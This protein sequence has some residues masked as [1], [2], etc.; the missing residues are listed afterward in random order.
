M[1]T[2][3]KSPPRIIVVLKLPEY[4]VPLLV[5]RARSI[6]ERMTGNQWFPSPM[7]SLAAVQAALED[8]FEAQA[9]TLSGNK[10]SVP[11]RDGKRTV[12]VLRL[13]QLRSYVEAIATA[14][15]EN[16][17]SIIESAGMYL[18]TG[19]G[20]AGRVFTAKPG[21]VSGE[22]DLVAPKA[23]NRAGYEFQH[24]LDGGMTWL[25]LPEPFTTKASVTFRRLK[26]GSTV[27]FRYRATVKGVTGNWSDSVAIIVE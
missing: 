23:G 5:T 7:P 21:R 10:S 4:E 27:H 2:S 6:V 26:P 9:A 1:S 18:K 13:Q 25:G 3:A 15:P 17:A 24:S 8:L 12:L 16:A 11:A 20:P 14:N 19:G 22:V